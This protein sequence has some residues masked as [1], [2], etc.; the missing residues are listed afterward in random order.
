MRAET[1]RFLGPFIAALLALGA[2][3]FGRAADT[4]PAPAAADQGPSINGFRSARFG[5]TQ[6]Q[7]RGAI[8]TGFGL[9]ASAIT[10]SVNPLQHTAVLTV[11]VPDLVPGGGIAS[12]SYV[13]GYQSRRLIEVSALWS[14]AIDPKITPT[15]LYQNGES[16][17]QYFASE[18][19]PA[20]R[21][22]GNVATP[23]GVLLFRATDP[24]GNAV[25]LIL[26]GTMSKD[27]K[28]G[29]SIL[30]PAALNLA[31]AMDPQHPDVFQLAKGSF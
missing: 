4:T 26:S 18:G 30:A 2:V 8:E 24:T 9:P 17:Q 6:A 13:F 3:H 31:Y 5:M 23:Q 20:Q 29:N 1:S 7:V 12:V 21:S 28:T 27:P 25:L 15:M 11:Q 10:S 22:T 14:K 19:F 16:L